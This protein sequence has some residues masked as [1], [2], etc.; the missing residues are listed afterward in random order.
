M[1]YLL[2][3]ATASKDAVVSPYLR[4]K[5]LFLKTNPFIVDSSNRAKKRDFKPLIGIY[6]ASKLSSLR[7][8]RAYYQWLGEAIFI[9]QPTTNNFFNYL[10]ILILLTT[11]KFCYKCFRSSS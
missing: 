9:P 2:N 8:V 5:A 7:P 11:S 10:T 1:I 6:R 3:R 4:F